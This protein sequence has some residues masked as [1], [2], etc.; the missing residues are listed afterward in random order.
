LDSELYSLAV[1]A[2][3]I[4]T[5]SRRMLVTAESCTGG[6]V[7]EA[8]TMVPG[9]SQWFERGF[10]T[11]TNLAKQEMLGVQSATLELHGAVSEPTVREMVAG[12]LMRSR[13]D[14]ALAVSGVAG[15]SG[16]TAAKP[17]GM[18]CLAWGL[19]GREVTV[20]T[21]HFPGDREAV[22]RLSVIAALDGLIRALQ[23]HPAS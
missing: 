23:A 3:R 19:R 15:P 4:L 11:Y 7:S 9:S 22:R 1:E 16:G 8:V 13:G 17:V 18:V 20:V 21:R 2:G 6:W 12:A 10:V 5:A 14:V